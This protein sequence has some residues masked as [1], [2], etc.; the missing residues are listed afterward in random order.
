MQYRA[1]IDGLRSIAIIPVVLYHAGVSL[2]RGGYVGVDVFFVISGYLITSILLEDIEKNRFS[3]ELFYFRRAKRIFPALFF[4][5]FI[6][7][8]LCYYLFV[9]EDFKRFAKSFVATLLFSSNIIFWRESGYFD[10]NSELKPLLHTWSL[11]VEEQFYIFFPLFL[12]FMT[13]KLR[14]KLNLT[15]IAIFAISLFISI[16]GVYNKPSATFYLLPTRAWELMLGAILAI[17]VLKPINTKFAREALSFFGFLLIVIS[18][19][20]YD[21][22]TLFP[23]YAAL[24]PCLGTFLIIYTGIHTDEGGYLL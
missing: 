20:F 2:F 17:G 10:I 18:I 4:L 11:S 9:P 13:K 8:F 7:Y 24:L 3:L 15:I 22:N 14:K 5:L 6:S 21:K 1:D 23:G 12:Y 19:F 16:W